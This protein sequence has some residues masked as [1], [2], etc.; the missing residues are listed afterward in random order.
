MEEESIPIY[1][2]LMKLTEKGIR[3]IKDAPEWIEGVNRAFGLRGKVLGFY[4]TMGEYDCV[5][6]FET[7]NDESIMTAL[8]SLEPAGNVRTTTLK[9]FTPKE[10]AEMMTHM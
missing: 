9:A 6:I 10:F 4:I 1:V 2:C 8:L 5:G 7:P 3:N